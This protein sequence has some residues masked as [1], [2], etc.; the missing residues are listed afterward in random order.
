MLGGPLL[1]VAGGL[2]LAPPHDVAAAKTWLFV[3]LIITNG[4][5]EVV[6]VP[7]GAWAVELT[8]DPN[9]RSLLF[10]IIGICGALG[11]VLAAVLSGALQAALGDAEAFK[12]IGYSSGA[13]GALAYIAVG[14]LVKESAAYVGRS[15]QAIIPAVRTCAENGQW[16][17]MMAVLL[18][19]S[20][21]NEITPLIVYALNYVL[22][23]DGAAY[24]SIVVIVFM[25]AQLLSILSSTWLMLR[26]ERR[27]VV[28]GGCAIIMLWTPLTFIAYM[29]KSP[30]LFFVSAFFFGYG[31][32]IFGFTAN[33]MVSDC[34]DLDEVLTGQRRE[35]VYT[36][37]TAIPG[38]VVGTMGS[39]IPLMALYAAGFVG[40][41]GDL[42][43]HLHAQNDSTLWVIKGITAFVPGVVA[44]G[45]MLIVMPYK[46]TRSVNKRVVELAKRLRKAQGVEDK[47]VEDGDLGEALL[48]SQGA[49]DPVAAE[50]GDGDISSTPEDLSGLQLYFS[51]RDLRMM[52]A[53]WRW[54]FFGKYA[55]AAA[56]WA[57]STIMGFT[58]VGILLS[59]STDNTTLANNMTLIIAAIAT[60]ASMGLLYEALRFPAIRQLLQLSKAD[61]ADWMAQRLA[62]KRRLARL[63]AALL[64]PQPVTS[65]G[66]GVEGGDDDAMSA[67]MELA[68][69]G[70]EEGDSSSGAALEPLPASELDLFLDMEDD[71]EG[72]EGVQ[73]G[74]AAKLPPWLPLRVAFRLLCIHGPLLVI[75]GFALFVVTNYD[76]WGATKDPSQI[77]SR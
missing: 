49:V 74:A 50:E 22:E 41:P 19:S 7:Y 12:W 27:T 18:A 63:Q 8:Q 46:L 77:G 48:Q 43:N 44:L 69:G 65:A 6:S 3:F 70:A 57:A 64:K 17:R 24:M 20:L 37:L 28:L 5:G 66:S 35:S 53:G 54:R 52:A 11:T 34:V 29:I 4:L 38:M 33:V 9:R 26:F 58:A 47:E 76:V 23:V 45:V 1:A 42:K 68:G 36:S 32:G 71:E 40:G 72:E 62:R 39:S 61:V 14:L 25:V 55:L 21:L 15:H 31:I 13:A 59:K 75:T 67:V 73:G 51:Y 60:L 30:V 56:L 2:L 16:L 10:A